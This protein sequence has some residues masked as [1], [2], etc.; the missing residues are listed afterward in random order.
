L[1]ELL[2]SELCGEVVDREERLE[3][4]GLLGGKLREVT[5]AREGIREQRGRGQKCILFSQRVI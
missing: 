3:Q 2:L 5:E 4:V 1:P